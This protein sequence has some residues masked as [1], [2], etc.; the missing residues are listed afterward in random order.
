[1]APVANCCTRTNSPMVAPALPTLRSPDLRLAACLLLAVLLHALLLLLPAQRAKQPVDALRQ[2]SVSLQKTVPQPL[3]PPVI[4]ES[5]SAPLPETAPQPRPAA[6][7]AREEA[8][9]PEATASPPGSPERPAE[10][11]TA[12]L[13]EL[14]GRREWTIDS[15][16]ENRRL[17][18]FQPQPL[19]RNWQPGIPREAN[20][21]D[22]MALPEQVEVVDRWLAADGSHNVVVNTPSGETYCGRAAAWSPSNPLFEPVMMWRPCG[23]G[24][25]RTFRMPERYD[26]A[27]AGTDRP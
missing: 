5:E 23:G 18:V 14:A 11:S 26:R 1:M 17:G 21:F 10:L 24:G 4:Q 12:R 25:K 20:L 3:S 22:D 19:P 8:V 27:A 9:P 15:P 16:G 7:P 2:L 6:D 13:L